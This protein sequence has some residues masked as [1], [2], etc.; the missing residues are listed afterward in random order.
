MIEI[1]RKFL[2]TSTTFIKK[3]YKK[4]TL[5]QGYLSKDP[6]R[7]VRV[8]VFDQKG[9]LTIKGRSSI[10]GRSRFEWEK[11]IDRADADQLLG[12]ALPGI[13]E[14]DRYLVNENNH[15]FEVDVFHGNHKGL[16]IAEIELENEDEKIVL[17]NWIGKEV[18]GE[19]EYYNSF[20]S[21]I[22]E[23]KSLN[24]NW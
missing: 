10:S 14:K 18:T 1:E 2:V 12:L 8:R 7:T 19:K 5:R 11:E 15:C 21:S 4:V 16:V 20:L 24:D 6:E 13:I 9:L 23:K 22:E 3:A 17:P